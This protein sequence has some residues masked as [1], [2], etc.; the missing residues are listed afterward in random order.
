MNEMVSYIRPTADEASHD[1][2]HGESVQ[3]E[4]TCDAS[5]GEVRPK[6][7][8]DIWSRPTT[9]LFSMDPR[10][11]TSRFDTQQ[12]AGLG[13]IAEGQP[14]PSPSQGGLESSLGTAYAGPIMKEEADIADQGPPMKGETAADS[15]EETSVPNIEETSGPDRD[16][17]SLP[18][19]VVAT[20]V[21]SQTGPSPTTDDTTVSQ[22]TNDIAPGE[23]SLICNRGSG[24]GT[25]TNQ[26]HGARRKTKPDKQ[27]RKQQ[28]KWRERQEQQ[29][30]WQ[31]QPGWQEEQQWQDRQQVQ[32]WPEG[33]Q[34]AEENPGQ[35]QPGTLYN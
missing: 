18:S 2:N 24:P 15:E 22:Q 9:P 1:L 8:A 33:Q 28:R 3:Y 17:V 34:Y 4:A 21:S 11:D 26:G 35:F 12:P 27:H 13:M 23:A 6:A 7:K 19:A 14:S 5:S 16:D 10:D 20:K 32:E 30:Q 29:Q 25:L 31:Q